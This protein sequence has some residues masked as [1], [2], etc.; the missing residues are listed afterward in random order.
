MSTKV[1]IPKTVLFRDKHPEYVEKMV[2]LESF[3]NPLQIA[4]LFRRKNIIRLNSVT[5]H[6]KGSLEYKN[7]I[8]TKQEQELLIQAISIMEYVHNNMYKNWSVYKQENNFKSKKELKEEEKL[9][10]K[11]SGSKK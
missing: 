3:S 10:D 8:Y 5:R 2:G 7:V 1:K 9:D 11:K 4:A 6:I